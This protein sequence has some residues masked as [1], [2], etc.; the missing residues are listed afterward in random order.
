MLLPVQV[1]TRFSR[2]PRATM[3]LLA[4]NLAAYVACVAAAAAANGR[5]LEDA[6]SLPA[7]VIE[8]WGLWPDHPTAAAF[9]TSSWIH[10]DILHLAG[11]LLFLWVFGAAAEETLGSGGVAVIY[12]AGGLSAA[13]SQF[14]AGWA[15]IAPSDVGYAGA[16]GSV[17]ALIVAFGLRRYRARVRIWLVGLEASIPA[18]IVLVV[19]SVWYGLSPVLL[20]EPGRAGS[21][22]GHLGGALAGLILSLVMRLAP[23]GG[24]DY[25]LEDAVGEINRGQLKEG[26]ARLEQL[27]REAPLDSRIPLTM[28]RTYARVWDRKAAGRHYAEAVQIEL[29]AGKVQSAE[30][31][32]GEA[33][34]SA[35]LV[36]PRLA[37]ALA[38]ALLAS[39]KA[40]E[41]KTLYEWAAE[42]SDEQSAA[43]SRQRLE[44]IAG[45]ASAGDGHP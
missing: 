30:E 37:L 7:S 2:V 15:G 27:R 6:V 12:L 29:S 22:W 43:I 23:Q 17:I 21:Y 9:L 5:L 34:K 36:H 20:S 25:Q 4:L 26:L 24:I 44:R 42:S 10:L 40:A 11:N 19:L 16:S 8:E 3:V 13:V 33:S 18:W 45:A 41:A 31:I 39:G 14:A 28:A 32:W 35:A 1:E 38:A